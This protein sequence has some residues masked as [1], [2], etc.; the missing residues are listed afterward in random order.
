LACLCSSIGS[1]KIYKTK[2]ERKSLVYVLL[3][4]HSNTGPWINGSMEGWMDGWL[5]GWMDGWMIKQNRILTC[6]DHGKGNPS[7]SN[8]RCPGCAGIT[9]ISLIVVI[10]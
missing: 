5:D 2:K 10:V 7:E 1:S 6:K 8:Y 3:R 9:D 4:Y